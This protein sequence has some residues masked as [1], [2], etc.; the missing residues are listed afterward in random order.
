MLASSDEQKRLKRAAYMRKWTA[1]NREQ[2]RATNRNSARKWRLAHPEAYKARI[3]TWKSKNQAKLRLSCANRRAQ[4]THAMPAWLTQ[5][6]KAE[7]LALY[8]VGQLTGMHVDHIIPL[9]GQQVCGLH[10]PWNLQLLSP[11]DNLAKSNML[12]EGVTDAS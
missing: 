4:Q 1:D 3:K 8:K 5:D 11:E 10:V 9:R 7:M 2:T 12:Q 6:Q